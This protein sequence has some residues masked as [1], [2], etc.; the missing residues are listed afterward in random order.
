M[1]NFIKKWKY[2]L[3]MC[4]LS[5]LAILSTGYYIGG[6]KGA[7]YLP[8]ALIAVVLF[9]LLLKAQNEEIDKNKQP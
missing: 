5:L 1:I 8:L 6:I 3:I 4:S 7:L 9:I 2:N